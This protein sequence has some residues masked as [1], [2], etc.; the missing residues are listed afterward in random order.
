MIVGGFV[1]FFPKY[2]SFLAKPGF[3]IEDIFV[4]EC[5]RG[6]G[7]GKKLLS[8]VAAQ[9]EA[10]GY[11]RVEWVVLDWNVDSIAFYERMGAKLMP[12]WRNFRLSGEELKVCARADV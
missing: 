6:K 4:R 1:I 5:C 9:A 10:M 8:A 7:L 2:A 12:E 11:E 3:Y